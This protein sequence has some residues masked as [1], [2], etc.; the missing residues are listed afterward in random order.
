MPSNAGRARKDHLWMGNRYYLNRP[1]MSLV[2]FLWIEFAY[3]LQEGFV[4][5]PILVGH[6]SQGNILMR[7]FFNRVFQFA[8]DQ[9][10]LAGKINRSLGGFSLNTDTFQFITEQ[11][12]GLFDRIDMPG[13]FLASQS[14]QG[15]HGRGRQEPNQAGSPKAPG[16]R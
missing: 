7:Y 14:F 15:H 16:A 9:T 4:R 1:M 6:V 11:I 13:F 12:I 3:H 10:R 2:M 5:Y 8:A